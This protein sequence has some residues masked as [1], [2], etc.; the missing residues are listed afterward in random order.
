MAELGEADARHVID[1]LDHPYLY[2]LAGLFAVGYTT[3][4]GARV[5][6]ERDFAFSHMVPHLLPKYRPRQV[7]I[8]EITDLGLEEVQRAA[9]DKQ[10]GQGFRA[11]VNA[12]ELYRPSDG[13][14]QVACSTMRLFHSCKE[15]EFDLLARLRDVKTGK[16]LFVGPHFD[17]AIRLARKR[18]KAS[19]LEA[20]K[21]GEEYWGLLAKDF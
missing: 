8:V 2:P 7:R 15:K 10:T 14:S 5:L 3:L 11:L 17:R 20:E 6:I 19:E 4:A 9:D 21:R 1:A 18:P 16:R 12:I 13:G